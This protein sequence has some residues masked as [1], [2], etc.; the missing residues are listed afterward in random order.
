MSPSQNAL[1]DVIENEQSWRLSASQLAVLV[2]SGRLSAYSVARQALARLEAVN[3]A[4]NAVVD[5]RSDDV[6]A[7]AKRIDER[8]A[9]GEEVGPLAGVP[10]TIKINTDQKGY[11]NTN[12]LMLQ[13]DLIADA[14]N[15]VVQRLIDA[16]AILLGRTNTPAFSARLFTNNRLHGH[17]Y[18]P[19]NKALTP[20]G[21]SGGAASALASGIGALAHGTDI[22]GSIR[23]P[24][25]ACGVHG[26][27]P[28]LGRV[29]NFNPSGA[30]RSIGPQL[31][32]VAGPL[33]RS[34]ADLRLA[35]EVMAQPD[36]RDVWY[37]PA[38]LHGTPKPKR[39]VVCLR[40]EGLETAPEIQRELHQA[41]DALRA[42][43]WV[44]DE[45]EELPSLKE[46]AS[47][48]LSLWLADGFEQWA[49]VAEQE[50]DVAILK[51]IDKARGFVDRL[52]ADALSSTLTKRATVIRQWKRFLA[53]YSLVLL[54]PAAELALPDQLD[55]T[56]PE[57]MSRGLFPMMAI[58][59][60]GIPAMTL[61][62]ALTDDNT[63][64]G[65]QL[66]GDSFRED[67]LLEA[68]GVIEAR[69]APVTIAQPEF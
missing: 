45:V 10:V 9:A 49:E 34:V 61:T 18:N 1:D 15:P 19:R 17:T 69:A 46:P 60:L 14:N 41:A 30:E 43:G 44:V 16:G 20:G 27:R 57:R 48:Q 38:P 66:L 67:I 56:D 59:V 5:Y 25:F 36:P 52:P 22:A 42:S 63:P 37:Q 8:L 55:L 29:A 21:S 3:P 24:A 39:A 28:T 26:L 32:S 54:P 31:M 58:P 2:N 7:Q 12:G 6:L 62:T 64:V 23:Y 51:M 50:G 68:G 11:A 35:L 40:P 33:A 53:Q 47:L 13:K 4:I 65:I